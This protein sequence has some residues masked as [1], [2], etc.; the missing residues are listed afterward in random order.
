ML[1]CCRC[2]GAQMNSNGILK[3][4]SSIIESCDKTDREA[5]YLI[6]WVR[7]WFSENL[8]FECYEIGEQ[9]SDFEAIRLMNNLNRSHGRFVHHK[10]VTFV[11]FF[12]NL[13]CLYCIAV[14]ERHPFRGFQ[15]F[16]FIH[17]IFDVVYSFELQRTHCTHIALNLWKVKMML[18]VFYMLT[19]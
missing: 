15:F 1:V 19:V 13:F 17:W 11:F 8:V 18:S 4:F 6:C 2:R 12:F 10:G 9:H 14:D 3:M 16:D 5:K 7:S